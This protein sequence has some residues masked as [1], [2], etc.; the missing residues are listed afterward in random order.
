M[1]LCPFMHMHR[2]ANLIGVASVSFSCS[3]LI[4][5]TISGMPGPF[6]NSSFHTLSKHFRTHACAEGWRRMCEKITDDNEQQR[7]QSHL[8]TSTNRSMRQLLPKKTSFLSPIHHQRSQIEATQTKSKHNDSSNQLAWG[9]RATK[10]WSDGGFLK[11][12][13]EEGPLNRARTSE[14]ERKYRR[15]NACRLISRNSF[16]LLMTPSSMPF[17]STNICNTPWAVVDAITFG[18]LRVLRI[19]ARKNE[20]AVCYIRLQW[21]INKRAGSRFLCFGKG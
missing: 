15:E 19:R 1:T 17:D 6:K 8:D 9:T 4:R 10:K 11:I 20:W 2:W 21:N 16:K 5:A 14:S 18:S 7:T 12:L 3:L 13:T